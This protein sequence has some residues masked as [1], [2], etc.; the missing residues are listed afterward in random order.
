MKHLPNLLTLTNLLFGCM[1]IVYILSAPVYLSTVTGETYFPVMSLAQFYYGG[2][3]I[4]LAAVCDLF[5]GLAARML[6]AYSPI[7]KDLDSLADLVSF[8]VA[9]ALILYKL[10]WMSYMQEPGALETPFWVLLPVFVPV[11]AAALRLARFNQSASAG[12]AGFFKGLPV[13]AV[14]LLIASF[15]LILW[16]PVA[17]IPAEA[18]LLNRWFLY[19]LALVLSYLMLSP[20]HFLKWKAPAGGLKAWWPQILLLLTGIVGAVLIGFTIVPVLFVLYLLFS[21]VYKFPPE[22]ETYSPENFNP[23][24]S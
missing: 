8:G 16:F 21:F 6:N 20:F 10:L 24:N 17:G 14:G 2:I 3:F 19:G 11:A 13:P 23:S 1:A 15:P 22:T 4:A 7:G 9:P 18:V 5:D 12:Q